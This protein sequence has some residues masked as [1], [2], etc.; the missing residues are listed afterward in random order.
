MVPDT[1][2]PRTPDAL[3]PNNWISFH[4]DGTI[5]LYPMLARNR[6]LERRRD[7]YRS[8]ER[9]HGFHVERVVD[10]TEHEAHGRAL[11]GTGSLV[12]DRENRIAYACS[13]PRTRRSNWSGGSKT[14]RPCRR[15]LILPGMPAISMP[16]TESVARIPLFFRFLQ[17]ETAMPP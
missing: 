17:P 9:D 10:L 3:F 11:E 4:A 8:L 12:L 14:A 1:P 13:S 2:E 15:R 7:V 6:R 5:V 16:R